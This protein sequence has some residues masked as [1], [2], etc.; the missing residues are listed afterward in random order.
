MICAIGQTGSAL[1]SNGTQLDIDAMTCLPKML[2]CMAVAARPAVLRSTTTQG[3][4]LET[5]PKVGGEFT[6]VT[7]S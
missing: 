5:Q 4:T 1:G 6:R 3:A 2:K 7:G